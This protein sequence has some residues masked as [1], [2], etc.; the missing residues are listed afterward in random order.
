MK[1]EIRNNISPT[2]SEWLT[3]LVNETEAVVKEKYPGVSFDKIRYRFFWNTDTKFSVGC[4]VLD[5]RIDSITDKNKII[6]EVM[7]ALSLS[8]EKQMNPH[9]NMFRIEEHLFTNEELLAECAPNLKKLAEDDVNSSYPLEVL[10]LDEY[11]DDDGLYWDFCEE[12]ETITVYNTF[13]LGDPGQRAFKEKK[14][15]TVRRYDGMIVDGEVV[16]VNGETWEI[17]E[18]TCSL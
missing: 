4:W 14:N 11:V 10:G 17:G 13:L 15:P 3:N 9:S 5:H 7:Y 12:T 8:A 2:K 6:D 16:L 1:I 18:E